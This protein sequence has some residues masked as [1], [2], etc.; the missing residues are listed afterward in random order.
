MPRIKKTPVAPDGAPPAPAPTAAAAASA[1]AGDQSPKRRRTEPQAAQEAGAAVDLAAAPVK[2]EPGVAEGALPSLSAVYPARP[3]AQRSRVSHIYIAQFIAAQQR[4]A[5]SAAGRPKEE[6]KT[7]GTKPE[8]AK[9]EDRK[10]ALGEV[11]SA[12]PPDA[13]QQQQVRERERQRQL[14]QL[15]HQE[16]E[17]QKQAEAMRQRQQQQ[18]A[19]QHQQAQRQA[20][21]APAQ[22]QTQT[23]PVQWQLSGQAQAGTFSS[24]AAAAAAAALAESAMGYS[25]AGHVVADRGA[26]ARPATDGGPVRSLFPCYFSSSLPQ[27]AI[28]LLGRLSTPLLS[29]RRHKRLRTTPRA[30]RR[31]P[32]RRPPPRPVRAR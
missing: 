27:R 17:M 14:Q 32:P 26:G 6:K 22:R 31:S 10:E 12:P 15:K 1:G 30:P 2:K 23:Q 24:A 4:R 9:K 7:E 19:Q 16:L 21:A 11:K 8:G 29:R 25:A 20:Q 18:Q 13:A 28:R 3:G 5:P